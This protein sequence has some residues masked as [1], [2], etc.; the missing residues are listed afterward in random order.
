MGKSASWL[1]Q[2]RAWRLHR[3]GLDMDTLKR[4]LKAK[5]VTEVLGLIA[6]A[7]RHRHGL[8]R[9]PAD[10]LGYRLGW[11]LEMIDARRALTAPQ[12]RSY[13]GALDMLYR[14]ADETARLYR[15]KTT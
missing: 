4:L 13:D 1:R 11:L 15:E 12:D 14:D 9:M 3:Q 6:G 7:Y 5:S 10:M 2:Q 8:A